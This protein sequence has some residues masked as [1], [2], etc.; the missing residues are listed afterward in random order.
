MMGSVGAGTVGRPEGPGMGLSGTQRGKDDVMVF[1]VGEE[2]AIATATS[3]QAGEIGVVMRGFQECLASRR[4]M[5][6]GG[7]CSTVVS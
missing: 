6:L 3:S 4:D 1:L 5:G 7:R 2:L